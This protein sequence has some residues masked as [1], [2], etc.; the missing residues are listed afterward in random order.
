MAH[1]R[2]DISEEVTAAVH[3]AIGRGEFASE[4]ELVTAA[5]ELW[6]A[7]RTFQSMGVEHIRAKWDEAIAAGGTYHE[8]EAVMDRL[9]A[10]Y[11]ARSAQR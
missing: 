4:S 6:R 7:E 1:L 2:I 3:E 5:L 9:E 11:R 10:K 8:P